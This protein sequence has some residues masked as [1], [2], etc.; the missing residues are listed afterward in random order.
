MNDVS[1]WGDSL[2]D[3]VAAAADVV[4][5]DHGSRLLSAGAVVE[6]HVEPG[7]VYGFIAG[8]AHEVSCTLRVEPL[9]E[10]HLA[11]LLTFIRH[12]PPEQLSRRF[13]E[14]LDK[15]LANRHVTLGPSSA[16]EPRC[17]CPDWGD[18]CKH[19]V[20][21]ALAL[22]GAIDANPWTWLRTRGL[23]IAVE[24]EVPD[25][26]DREPTLDDELAIYWSGS[27]EGV[28]ISD[29]PRP[30]DRERDRNVLVDAL[31]PAFSTPGRTR[32]AVAR[33]AEEA[34]AGFEALYR[35]LVDAPGDVPPPR[36]SDPEG[37]R[38]D[39]AAG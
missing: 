32:A 27:Q 4:V 31:A 8:G 17:E 28:A 20:A 9:R 15:A 21:L 22:A 2:I 6:W 39:I 26:E 7:G 1:G 24:P 34:A 29:V 35:E 16:P 33:L 12:L 13:L 5:F 10:D 19:S 38:R 14:V 37:P 3:R 25:V 30:A 11:L 23:E 18:Y 36:C